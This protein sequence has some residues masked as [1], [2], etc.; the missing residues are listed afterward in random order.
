MSLS[1]RH[2]L[3]L[4]MLVCA[5][6]L[7]TL[8]VLGQ[9]DPTGQ[10]RVTGTYAITNATVY[11]SPGTAS[12]AT[13][14]I[15]NGLIDG[16]GK[17]IEVPINAQE[18]KGDSLFVYA[19]FIDMASD[20]GVGKSPIPER[21]SEFDPSDPPPHLAGIAPEKEVLDDF[22]QQN[23][24]IA[25]WRKNGFT[26][27]QL[28]PQGDGMLPGKTAIALYGEK[29]SSN[30]LASSTGLYA[31]FEAIR[32]IYPGT[33]LGVMAKWRELYQN[34][35]LG[36]QH[37][38]IFD[39]NEGIIRPE[40]DIVLEAFVPVIE[41]KIPVNFEVSDELGMRRAL[42]LQNEKDFRLILSDVD[43]G[44]SLIPRI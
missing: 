5:F 25:D 20:A 39:S 8:S 43:E 21:P 9:S 10:K 44:S 36:I 24:E 7:F 37:Q 17:N 27:V 38:S 22:N 31:K 14:I 30:I 33:I 32:G 16:V 35:E 6:T 2:C 4:P 18:I 12:K 29:E 34:A 26:L 23:E 11:T 1:K 15:K 13:V 3:F 28:V 19:G 41:K 42:N 40:K